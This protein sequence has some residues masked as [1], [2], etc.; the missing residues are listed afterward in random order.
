MGK[1]GYC[2]VSLIITFLREIVRCLPFFR[3]PSDFF[4]FGLFS[5]PPAVRSVKYDGRATEGRDVIEFRSKGTIR[6]SNDR[7]DETNLSGIV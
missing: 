5:Y 6:D 2:R 4:F 7:N 1:G 3:L